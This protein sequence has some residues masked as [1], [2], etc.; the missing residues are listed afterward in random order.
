MRRLLVVSLCL[1]AGALAGSVTAGTGA[2]A[3]HPCRL[4]SDAEV[5]RI[6]GAGT[7][8]EV[9]GSAC[10]I[11]RGAPRDIG[12]ITVNPDTAGRFAAFRRG[13]SASPSQVVSTIAGLGQSAFLVVRKDPRHI[14][15]HSVFVFHRGSR[16]VVTAYGKLRK[17]IDKATGDD[18]YTVGPSAVTRTAAR[19]IAALVASRM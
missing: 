11:V 12:V 5:A 1:S 17:S 13:V 18:V 16:L 7:R 15:P 9:G 3:V 8:V 19:R 14:S 6:V 2:S 4:I 10:R